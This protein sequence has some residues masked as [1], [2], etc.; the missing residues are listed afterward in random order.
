[1]GNDFSLV[2]KYIKNYKKR[3]LSIISSIIL[4]TALIVGVGTLSRSAQQADLDRMKRETGTYHVRFKDIDK[5]QLDIIKKQNEIKDF[6]ISSSYASTDI[7]EKL[8]INI[9]YAS[10]N[11]LTNTSKLLKGRFPKGQNEVV[12]EEWVLN[13]MGLENNLNQEVSFKLYEKDKDETFKIVGI[14]KD[15]YQEKSQGI[16]EMFLYLDENKINK[17]DVYVEL[18]EDSDID[19]EID[20]IAKE[21][22]MSKKEDIRKNTMLI[23]S[24][25]Q[26]GRLDNESKISALT[27]SIF[28]G[29][30]IYSIYT[31]SIYQRIREYGV[32]K[33]LGSTNFKIFKLMMYEL[34]TLSLIAMPIGIF[35]GISGAQIFNKLAGN[36]KFDIEGVVTPFVIPTNTIILSILCT[37][38][39]MFIIS[40]SSYKK[41]KNISPID[42]I[43]KNLNKDEKI[44]K[45]NLIIYKITNKISPTKSI[46]TRNILRNKKGFLIIIL[47]MSIGGILVIRNNYANVG[48]EKLFEFG[49]LKRYTNGDFILTKNIFHNE[50]N[51]INKEQINEIKNI[52]GIKEVKTASFLETRMDIPK[53]KMLDLKY[54]E[55]LNEQSLRI[56]NGYE[57]LESKELDGYVIKQKLKGYNDEM[58][59]SLNDYVVSGEINIENMKNS[60]EVVLYIPH[61]YEAY[62]GVRDVSIGSGEPVVDIKVGD[63]VKIK[64]PKDEIDGELYWKMKDNDNYEY[65]Y[66]EFKVGAIVNYPFADDAMYS[67][68]KGVD[69]IT[70]SSYLEKI[71]GINTYD[72][73]YANIDDNA[74]HKI[75]N[76][77]LGKIGSKT[78]G[79]V[80]VDTIEEKEITEKMSQKTIMYSYG[81]IVIIFIISAFN[82]VNNVSYN[83]ASRTN[84]FGMLRA[85][86]ITDTDF[87]NMITYEGILYGVISS[88]IVIIVGILIQ[89]R[90]YTTFG[91]EGYGIE[92]A[93]AYKEYILVIIT[94]I[95]IGLITTYFPSRKIKKG[96]I[97]ESINIIE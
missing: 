13:S 10:E 97:V 83:I 59:K 14:L 69:V 5:E 56:D 39:V 36:I 16:C 78:P 21:I 53:E 31:I 32:L 90:I 29:L 87:R 17:Y 20:N 63:T 64:I 54:Y 77:Q 27:M 47:S 75:I 2:I 34:I 25:K 91:Y 86:G 80:T 60:N 23:D 44:K 52:E 33:A 76:K 61:T 57:I 81:V 85:M 42:A 66:Y 19:K 49:D 40:I 67:S 65:K 15:R 38:I 24:V 37:L 26:N 58:I 9:E 74:D 35:V 3:S 89:I 71:T 84:E 1:M 72:L 11:Y 45:N 28:S 18:Q 4:G 79:T 88:I 30:V 51:G 68:D 93:I 70:S 6:S 7:G 92:F 43:R 8:P 94:N 48:N 50:N 73:V 46:S 95:G 41:I 62:E 55:M 22:N 96:N 82:I 12:V